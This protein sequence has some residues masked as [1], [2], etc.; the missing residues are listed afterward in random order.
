METFRT[1]CLLVLAAVAGAMG[2]QPV[3]LSA[4][5]LSEALKNSNLLLP[6]Q[7]A[8][9]TQAVGA[10]TALLLNQPG[11]AELAAFHT[12][13]AQIA[14]HKDTRLGRLF[15]A[16][17]DACPDL[18]QISAE[19]ESARVDVEFPLA[20]GSALRVQV[21]WAR[22]KMQWLIAEFTIDITGN[23]GA[24]FATA[25]PYFGIGRPQPAVLDAAELDYLLGRDP[26]QRLMLESEREPFDFDAALRRRCA[27]EA[28]A[29][30]AL[31]AKLAEGLTDRRTPAEK[32][33]LLAPHLSAEAAK[34]LREQ[35]TAIAFWDGLQKQLALLLALPRA[36]GAP[37]ARGGK[38]QVGRTRQGVYVEWSLSR[39]DTGRLALGKGTVDAAGK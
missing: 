11:A 38:V 2:A 24:L 39:Q 10:V 12:R 29:S 17:L 8:N 9:H 35:G 1:F 20:L 7:D 30:A 28:G 37:A 22:N 19:D 16:A 3:T 31:L 25:G 33:E 23:A 26:A 15:F 32:T 27:L 14:Q 18:E 4:K 6:V 13:L 5:P 21:G 36:T 34:A